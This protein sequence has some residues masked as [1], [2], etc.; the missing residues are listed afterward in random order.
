MRKAIEQNSEPFVVGIAKDGRVIYGGK[1]KGS[2][3]FY[4]ECELDVCNGRYEDVKQNVTT[5]TGL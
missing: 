1:K 3:E 5:S 2:D 4:S